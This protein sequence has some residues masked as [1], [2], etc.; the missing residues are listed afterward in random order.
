MICPVYCSHHL[1]HSLISQS[2]SLHVLL[3]VVAELRELV[4][5][6]LN[7]RAMGAVHPDAEVVTAIMIELGVRGK[8]I[9]LPHEIV[10][11]LPQLKFTHSENDEPAE[12]EAPEN[13]GAYNVLCFVLFVPS[14]AHAVP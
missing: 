5:A 4:E 11:L 9:S 1:L 8:T 14:C 10:E 13:L 12:E 6:V 2:S 3:L 7:D